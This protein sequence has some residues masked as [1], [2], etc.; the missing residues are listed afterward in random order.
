MHRHR[1]ADLVVESNIPLPEAPSAAG[2][3]PECTF[4]CTPVQSFVPV[5]IDSF[6][7]WI[8]LKGEPCAWFFREQTGYRIRFRDMADFLVSADADE[9]HC[10]PLPEVPLET[11]RHLLLDQ[12]LPLVLSRRGRITLHAS[13]IATPAG[14]FAFVGK[15]GQ[16]KSTLVAHFAQNNYSILCDDGMVLRERAGETLVV[17]SYPGIRLWQ[18]SLSALFDAD[19]PT[20]AVA[21]YSEKRRLPLDRTASSDPVALGR[22]YILSSREEWSA[23]DEAGPIAIERLSAR[24]TMIELA[25]YSYVL[26]PTD[27]Q[28]LQRIFHQLVPLA[29]GIPCYRLFIPYDFS[30]LAEVCESVMA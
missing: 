10:F 8:D 6:H 26:D 28:D 14:V 12:V 5:G 30:R 2:Q 23:K 9:I 19:T 20:T 15:S 21:H 25:R 7:N 27:H 24:E 11:I 18:D 13:A 1:I 17:P 4:R 29:E 16:G 3:K 22:I